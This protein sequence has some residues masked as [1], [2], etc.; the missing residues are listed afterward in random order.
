MLCS[1]LKITF[2]NQ[3]NTSEHTWQY[4]HGLSDYF[5]QVVAGYDAVLA[6]PFSGEGAD[7]AESDGK[8][9]HKKYSAHAALI[10][11]TKHVEWAVTWAELPIAVTESYV[12]LIPTI[13]GGTHVNGFRSG[14]L[15]AVKEFCDYR[16]LIP[17]QIKLT[18]D[19][20]SINCHYVLSVK[21]SEPQFSGQ[22]KERLSSRE[23]AGFVTGIVKDSFSLWLNKHPEEAE[24]LA[25]QVL[26]NAQKRVRANKKII[27]KRIHHGPALPGKLADC[28][29][30]DPSV[31]ELFL[32]EGDSAGG[33]ARQ[34]R[35]KNFQ[36]VMPLRGKILNTW[37]VDD[38]ELLGSREIHD[39][40][41][42]LGVDAHSKDTDQLR[43]HKICILADAD[44]DGLHI[45]TLLCALFVQHFPDLV[46][47]GHI[48][49]A[50]P[51]LYR[52]DQE[53]KVFYALDDQEKDQI[54]KR[55]SEKSRKPVNV[56]RFKG[57]GEMNPIQLRET[58]MHPDTRKLMRLSVSD[59]SDTRAIMDRLLAKKRSHDRKLWL[60]AYGD[61][62]EVA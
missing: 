62:A 9:K 42:A 16:N 45:A 32:V 10:Q 58:T 5:N 40:A 36:A 35:D 25:E 8:D 1:G 11:P 3:Q 52:I 19:D 54:I 41:V 26:I 14:L 38:Q 28:L 37:E 22:T 12:N 31:S 51:P 50:M 48:Y 57:L 46:A 17:R 29:S 6:Q 13:Q 7:S 53:Q 49:V 47:A 2:I 60:E 61:Q 30:S 24:A 21:L 59:W 44:S 23:A 20:I 33:S 43:Y 39:I 56:Q 34:A 18:V 27:R 55:L 15:E 4:K